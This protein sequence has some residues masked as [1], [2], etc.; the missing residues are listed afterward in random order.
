[1]LKVIFLKMGKGD[2]KEMEEKYECGACNGSG[3]TTWGLTCLV[4][5]GR[6]TIQ[7]R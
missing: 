7:E 6:G 5:Q 3:L 2:E 1:M 4:C